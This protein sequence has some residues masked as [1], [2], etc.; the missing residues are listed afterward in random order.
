VE[1]LPAAEAREFLPDSQEEGDEE[2]RDA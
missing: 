2:S 1:S